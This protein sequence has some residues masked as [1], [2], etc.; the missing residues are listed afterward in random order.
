MHLPAQ[1]KLA[2]ESSG[3]TGA[4]QEHAF[5]VTVLLRATILLG[6]GS[7]L[8]GPVIVKLARQWFDDPNYSHGFFVPLCSALLLWINRK[9]WIGK[10]LEPSLT[11]LLIVISA[12][13]L[14]V[15]GSLGAELFLSRAS[16]C[17]LIGGLV[18]YF[19]GWTIFRS[20][21]GPWLLLFLMIPLPA[22]IFN[23]IAFPL[24]LLA[25]RLACSVLELLQVP[26]LR[27]GNVI[28]LPSMAL[29]IV[30]ACSGL[31]S[32][33][34]LITVAVFYGLFFER[35][36]WMRTLLVFLAIPVAVLA[37]ALRIAFSAL[38]AEYV[39]HRL[40]EGFFHA[41]SGFL[42]FLLSLA[43]LAGFHALGSRLARRRIA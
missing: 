29:D 24:Q 5:N 6:L 14:L 28:V 1:A 43:A 35:R 33:M 13:G 3:Q 2:Q 38:L 7:L 41:F 12:M 16:L 27:E 26:V 8:Y 36:V 4:L 30:E 18:V 10:P 11:G 40:A 15:V 20:V 23:Q 37:N 39:S 22:I 34:S 19:A 42:L 31:R 21:L 32:L 17:I 25:S 9:S